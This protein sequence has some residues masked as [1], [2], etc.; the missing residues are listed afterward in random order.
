MAG[1][2][3]G[4]VTYADLETVTAGLGLDL[5]PA[6][7]ELAELDLV[8]TGS[9]LTLPDAMREL[10]VER[11]GPSSAVHGAVAAHFLAAVRA[12][13]VVPD[14]DNVRAALAWATVHAPAHFDGP[15]VEALFRHYEQT[16][17]LAEGQHTLT[18]AGR[19]GAP[20]AYVRAG[21]LA[22]L[23]GDLAAAARLA[24]LALAR[25]DPADHAGRGL[26]HLTLGSTGTDRRDTGAARTHLRAALVHARRAGD[27]R[28][29]GRVL[30]NL[31][32]LCMELGRLADAERLLGAAL[33][34]K[35][36][37]GAGPVDRGRTLFNLAETALD[38]GRYTVAAAQARAAADLLRDGHPR[39]AAFA[40]TTR[41]LAL[42]R[43][44]APAEAL[45]AARTAAATLGESGDDRRTFSVIG[46]RYSVIL[47]ATADPAAANPGAAAQALRQV[48]AAALDSTDRDRDEAANALASHARLLASADP[49][50]AAVLLG[51]AA[52][53]RTTSTRPVS[54]S[55]ARDAA[56][57][58]TAARARLGAACFDSQY[59]RGLTLPHHALLTAAGAIGP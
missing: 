18:R 42:L 58:T 20:L 6:L 29:T 28:L 51:A 59:T 54:P 40:G 15:L 9:R 38:A 19:A 4:G 57:A 43:L 32:T 41:A 13:A 50:T 44:G 34:A 30:N 22:R 24:Q 36:R 5:L 3:A 23:R 46:L 56:A 49:A 37:C 45:S 16:G 31:G 10:A 1:A 11:L 12:G 2:F 53:I 26:A 48:L 47:H 7:T 17:R 52:R 21:Q 33:E 14:V 8:R 25:L 27:L 35:R 39:L 55:T